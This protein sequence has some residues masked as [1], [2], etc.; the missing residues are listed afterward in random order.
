LACSGSAA[1]KKA[2]ARLTPRL[3]TT[4]ILV[5]VIVLMSLAIASALR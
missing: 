3:T 1:S 5:L 2:V 4:A